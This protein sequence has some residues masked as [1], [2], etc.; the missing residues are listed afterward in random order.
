MILPGNLPSHNEVFAQPIFFLE[1]RAD[2]L[3]LNEMDP[4]APPLHENHQPGNPIAARPVE[5]EIG[6]G[7]AGDPQKGGHTCGQTVGGLGLESRP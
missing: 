4:V 5:F 6:Y 2:L 1:G 7:R 3:R